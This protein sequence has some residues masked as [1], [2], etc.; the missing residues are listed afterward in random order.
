MDFFHHYVPFIVRALFAFSFITAAISNIIYYPKKIKVITDRGL[1]FPV[2]IFWVGI[3]MQCLGSLA[4]LFDI[5]LFYGAII[6]LVFT[7][8]ASLIFHDFWNC[9]G[10]ACRLKKQGLLSNVSIVAGLILLLD[11]LGKI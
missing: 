2:F 5:Y 1:P 9:T 7:V 6:L 10:D 11:T 8:L 3:V 4:I